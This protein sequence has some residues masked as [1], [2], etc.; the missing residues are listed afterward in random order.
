MKERSLVDRFIEFEDRMISVESLTKYGT[1]NDLKFYIFDYNP[2]DEI[3]IRSEVKKIKGRNPNIVEFDLYNLIIG[4]LKEK[5]FL[6]KAFELEVV[7]GRDF[8]KRA[9]NT[10]LNLTSESNLIIDHI[11]E[12]SPEN[13]IVFLTGIGKSYPLLRS[14]NILNNLHQVLDEV[15][16]IMFFPGK[17]SGTDLN[18]FGTIQDNN[19]Y[20]A[21]R[22]V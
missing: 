14:H 16:I 17:Y 8:V 12:N 2:Q 4:I 13:S 22:L 21:F 1:A 18:L 6:D 11:K 20:R 15:P 7:K 5:G 19:Y 9:I 3:T 10:L